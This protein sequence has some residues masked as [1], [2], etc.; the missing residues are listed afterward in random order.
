MLFSLVR[1]K[2]AYKCRGGSNRCA[3]VC[4]KG[5][6]MFLEIS[7]LSRENTRKPFTFSIKI[8]SKKQQRKWLDIFSSVDIPLDHDSLNCKQR[9]SQPKYPRAVHSLLY[10][11]YVFA[12]YLKKNHVV[13]FLRKNRAFKIVVIQRFWNSKP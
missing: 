13:S 11:R 3:C 6:G 7:F 1:V 4:A 8:L 12:S 9:S 2:D 10:Y 5:S